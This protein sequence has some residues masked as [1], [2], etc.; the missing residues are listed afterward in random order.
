[1]QHACCVFDNNCVTHR[2]HGAGTV[3]Q[4]MTVTKTRTAAMKFITAIAKKPFILNMWKASV[5]F[6]LQQ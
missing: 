6:V 2:H 4:L 5:A 1:M 3:K